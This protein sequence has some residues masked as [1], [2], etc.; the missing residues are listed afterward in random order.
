MQ[1]SIGRAREAVTGSADTEATV[2]WPPDVKG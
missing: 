1:A 2:F